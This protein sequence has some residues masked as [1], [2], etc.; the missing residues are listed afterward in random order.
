MLRQLHIMLLLALLIS[1]TAFTSAAQTGAPSDAARSA[2][3]TPDWQSETPPFSHRE[4][5]NCIAYSPDG[6]Q[7][8][9]TNV[10]FP[11]GVYLWDATTGKLLRPLRAAKENSPWSEVVVFSPH[12]RLVAAGD[13]RGVLSVWEAQSGQLIAS[14]PTDNRR[15]TGVAFL[16]NNTI[17]TGG[18]Q[19]QFALYRVDHQQFTR[20]WSAE[21]SRPQ[22]QPGG[23]MVGLA[24]LPMAVSNDGRYIAG[25]ST[26]G[27]IT[28]WDRDAD[29]AHV[30]ID[31]PLGQG[32]GSGPASMHFVPDGSK[33]ISS[34]G[35]LVKKETTSLTF[36]PKNM[37][38]FEIRV[39]ERATGNLLAEFIPGDVF[40]NGH[41]ALSP[42]G[43]SLANRS[44]GGVHVW[45]VGETK[46]FLHIPLPGSG[47]LS[48]RAIKFS[49]DGTQVATGN[50]NSISIWDLNGN[51]LLGVPRPVSEVGLVT[52]NRD[53]R[54][55]AVAGNAGVEIWNTTTHARESTHD[56]GAPLGPFGSGGVPWAVAF[57]P[58]GGTLIAAGNRDDETTYRAGI[59]RF[60]DLD[61]NVAKSNRE[62]LVGRQ[63]HGM[64][65]D[66]NGSRAVVIT[67]NGSIGDTILHLYNVRDERRLAT[68][69]TEPIGNSG[70]RKPEA[71]QLSPDGRYV[72]MVDGNGSAYRW[73]VQTGAKQ[74]QY[75]ADA[76]EVAP[77]ISG[78]VFGAVFS[79]DC[80]TLVV[81]SDK[82]LAFWDHEAGKLKQTLRDQPRCR[83]AVSPDGRLLAG[84]EFRY[85]GEPSTDAIHIWEMATGREILQLHPQDA[86]A[87]SLSFSPDS[88]QLLTGFDRG[89]FAIWDVQ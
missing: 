69:P 20:K 88:K 70:I 27:K 18:D 51:Q 39:W 10:N 78:W 59:L 41:A 17:V 52:W 23:G 38:R 22:R 61:F 74:G 55:I 68:F 3:G 33:L 29:F 76:R 36:G 42:D 5:V 66:A 89:T 79:P 49:P 72:H 64:V 31:Q 46:P 84:T 47:G 7:I 75:E 53:I 54:R 15:V 8:A 2:A 82:L 16:D 83:L 57:S 24:N 62:V 40:S 45:R 30:R 19:N 13:V 58:D 77:R 12:G 25:V 50:G 6:K 87:T 73:D 85:P 80:R 11:G 65:L 28:I 35:P 60:W 44:F 14:Q 81:S 67:G 1:L 63:V 4:N 43:K 34:A 37:Q 26:E 32:L 56:L 21:L 71:I 9:T 86:R 48:G